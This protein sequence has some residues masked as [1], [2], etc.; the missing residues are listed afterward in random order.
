MTKCDYNCNGPWLI[1][2]VQVKRIYPFTVI[3]HN[4]YNGSS[5]RIGILNV[6]LITLE[7][8]KNMFLLSRTMVENGGHLF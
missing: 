7:N 4:T 1:K 3:N 6:K 8:R 2:V 5:Q